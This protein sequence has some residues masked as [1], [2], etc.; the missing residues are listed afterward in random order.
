MMTFDVPDMHCG[1]CVSSVARILSR[2]DDKA[3]VEADLETRKVR[4]ETSASQDA[5]LKAL[6]AAGFPATAR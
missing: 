6:A 4:V 1:G 3:T 5:V 2:L